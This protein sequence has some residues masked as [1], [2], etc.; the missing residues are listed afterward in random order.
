MNSPSQHAVLGQKPRGESHSDERR[1]V[2]KV[3]SDVNWPLYICVATSLPPHGN[4]KPFECIDMQHM[5]ITT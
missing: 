3:G 4:A 2:Y 1:S 5:Q